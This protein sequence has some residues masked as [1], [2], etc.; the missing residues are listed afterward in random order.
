MN[1]KNN[2]IKFWY[3]DHLCLLY[4]SGHNCKKCNDVKNWL[5]ENTNK[6]DR[7]NLLKNIVSENMSPIQSNKDNLII[8]IKD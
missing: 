1:T 8:R 4:R 7:N 5:S 2:K 6:K 3:K